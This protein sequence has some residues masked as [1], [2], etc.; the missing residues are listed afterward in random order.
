MEATMR[1]GDA[2]YN[3]DGLSFQDIR[4]ITLK[5]VAIRAAGEYRH[6]GVHLGGHRRQA[7]AIRRHRTA[8]PGE[9]TDPKAHEEV[10]DR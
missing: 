6:P 2:I 4:S 7:G 3:L 5:Q 1:I 9:A 8:R 10:G